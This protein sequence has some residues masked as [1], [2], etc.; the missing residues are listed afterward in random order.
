MAKNLGKR[1][2]KKRKLES[3][4][5]TRDSRGSIG[6]GSKKKARKLTVQSNG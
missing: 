2:A 3:S 4:K 5:R 6:L 1:H